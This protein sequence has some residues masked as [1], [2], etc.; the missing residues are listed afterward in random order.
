MRETHLP[1]HVGNLLLCIWWAPSL[2]LALISLWGIDLRLRHA[3][4][5]AAAGRRDAALKVYAA[6]QSD[7]GGDLRR[8]R[9]GH[10]Q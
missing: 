10:A 3:R 7:I 8:A 1:D 9:R 4:R 6:V 2:V 5:L